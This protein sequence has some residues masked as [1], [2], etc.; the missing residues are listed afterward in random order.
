LEFP[1]RLI[2]SKVRVGKAS[3]SSATV[4]PVGV[5]GTL[6]SVGGGAVPWTTTPLLAE[7]ITFKEDE[8]TR[9]GMERKRSVRTWE[10]SLEFGLGFG[11]G[12]RTTIK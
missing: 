9:P 12:E 3:I 1:L 2:P 11:K 5:E 10:R 6:E 7:G 8:G 4:G